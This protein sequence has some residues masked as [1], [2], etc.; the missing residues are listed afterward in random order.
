MADYDS[1]ASLLEAGTDNMDV[2]RDNNANDDGTDSVT[3]I[4][5]FTYNNKVAST[6]YVS[7]NTWFGFGENSEHLKVDRRDAKV[8]SIW[9]EEGEVHGHKFLKIRWKGYSYYSSTLSSYLL[10]YDVIMFDDMSILLHMVN[11]PTSYNDGTYSLTNSAGTITYTVTVE[12]PN[13]TFVYNSSTNLYTA[14]NGIQE[15]Y[16]VKYL[17]EAAGV[18][19]N[20][21]DGALNELSISDLS[22]NIFEQYGVDKIPSVDLLAG[23]NSPS[24]LYWQDSSNTVPLIVANVTATPVSQI[25]IS[26]EIFIINPSIKGIAGAVCEYEGSPLVAISFD[27]KLSWKYFV[28]DTDW[29]TATEDF[30]GMAIDKLAT[31]TTEQWV[32]QIEQASSLFIKVMLMSLEDSVTKI[33]IQF[34]NS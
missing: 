27:G 26:E 33:V 20:I 8:Y 30:E 3:G 32:S 22:A 21:A 6:V 9:R 24:I 16:N 29:V 17:I 10:E 23:L 7:G 15:F 25:I 31:I 11:I 2:I 1:I 14:I 18:Y 19:Y 12:S 5:W 13:V 28:G 4:D 34:I